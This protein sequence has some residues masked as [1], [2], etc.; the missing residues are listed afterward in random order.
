MR[1]RAA[2]KKAETPVATTPQ[3]MPPAFHVPLGKTVPVSVKSATAEEIVMTLSDGTKLHIRPVVMTI[4]RSLS[5]Y[6]PAG[7]PLYQF[8]VGMM[9]VTN[10]PKRLKRVSKGG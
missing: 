5:K 6:N 1:K 8:N 10:V 7:D 9:V 2:K 4:E 3:V